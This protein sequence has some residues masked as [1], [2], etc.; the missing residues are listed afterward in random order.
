VPTRLRKRRTLADGLANQPWIRDIKGA[1]TV[2]ALVQFLEIR[3]R[4]QDFAL[5]P[6]MPDRLE[7]K[8]SSS[9]QFST[10]PAY[11]TLF[12]GAALSAR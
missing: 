3:Q 4:L 8:W 1:L 2:Q 11:K 10:G 12:L 7:W 6:V 5:D 9:G